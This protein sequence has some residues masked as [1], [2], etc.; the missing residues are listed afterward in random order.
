[1]DFFINIARPV[2]CTHC[3]C[4]TH[5]KLIIWDHLL[6]LKDLLCHGVW[7]PSS[8]EQVPA[9]TALS[10]RR[11]VFQTTASPLPSKRPPSPSVDSVRVA[12][13]ETVRSNHAAVWRALCCTARVVRCHTAMA[14]SFL[15]SALLIGEAGAARHVVMSPR[16][17]HFPSVSRPTMRALSSQ[18][19]RAASSSFPCGATSLGAQSL[20]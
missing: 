1:M 10:D 9:V 15:P 3:A 16:Q 7:V 17:P 18:R 12:S 20:K 8:Q 14:T 19:R 13:R 11:R 6:R 2:Q 5:F 4:K